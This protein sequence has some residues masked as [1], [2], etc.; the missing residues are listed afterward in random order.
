MDE[1]LKQQV[2][3]QLSRHRSRNEI[4]RMVCEQSSVNWPEAEQLVKDLETEQAHT[5]ARKQSPLMIFLSIGSLLIGAAMLAVSA[6]FFIAFFQGEP[7]AM[8]LS[9]RSGY[10]RM[11]SGLTGAGMVIGGL[12]GLYNTMA[13]FFET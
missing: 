8:I 13:S 7:L 2:I 10:L 1:Q 5:I 11:I 12:I 4:I 9:L 3:N 6:E